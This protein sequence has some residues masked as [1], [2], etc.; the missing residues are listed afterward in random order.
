MGTAALL[1]GFKI[2][3]GDLAFHLGTGLGKD[4]AVLLDVRGFL[5][6]GEINDGEM[7][8]VTCDIY[9]PLEARGCLH[10]DN[11]A[12]NTYYNQTDQNAFLQ[13]HLLPPLF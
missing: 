11:E 6:G 4:D 13:T 12:H 9:R 3:T 10:S 8:A 5:Q 1:H 7:S 2:H